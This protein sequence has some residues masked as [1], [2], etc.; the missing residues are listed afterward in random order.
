MQTYLFYDVE[1]T[2]LNPA[3]DQILT[4]A[5]IR[6]DL[7]LKELGRYEITIRLRKDIV[8]SPGAFL[9]HGLTI[10]VLAN[11]VSEYSAARQI[12]ELLN[13]PGT[14]SVGYNSLGFDD[15]F[16]RFL[17]YRN[18]LDP[19]SHQYANGCARMD[20]LPLATLYRVFH[21]QGV[22]WPQKDGIPSLKLEL[23]ARE[24]NFQTS[25][26]A[27]EAMNDVEALIA[28]AKK[29]RASQEIWNFGCNFFNKKRDDVRI[30]SISSKLSFN[31]NE[32]LH[33]LLVSAAFG[34]ENNYLSPSLCIGASV[35]YSNQTLWLRL[36]SEDLMGIAGD[37]EPEET[38]VVR[39]RSA[40]NLI[41]LP[42]L[43]RF[44]EKIPE[45]VQ[46]RAEKNIQFLNEHSD[47]LIR[48]MEFHRHFKY[49]DIPDI[50]SD[51]SLYQSGFFSRD[52][53]QQI[54][55]F[56]SGVEKGDFKVIEA[57]KSPRII[58]I[59]QRILA[60]N[61]DPDMAAVG[62]IETILNLKDIR[63]DDASRPVVGY[64]NEYKLTCSEA[65][66]ELD[67]FKKGAE[68]A[69]YPEKQAMINWLESYIR[70]L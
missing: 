17:F 70:N 18:L 16:L 47:R 24:N 27:H 62:D 35:P 38:F 23:I 21:P 12:H 19:Y 59:A 36:D 50:D 55:M 42:M 29:L 44:V 8:P 57:L 13:T 15:E 6:T 45:S 14:I 67:V 32:F 30:Q 56:H 26:K 2:G 7:N 54:Q 61:Y 63:G 28:L 68:T 25:G 51:A 10:E 39:K 43:D 11:G 48:Y 33:A 4:F 53:K 41:V 58:Q 46:G 31:D 65:M 49:P 5:A 9:T 37:F 3:F 1:T 34:P 64:R 52:E 20:I 66:A 69:K 40:D 22:K 60:R